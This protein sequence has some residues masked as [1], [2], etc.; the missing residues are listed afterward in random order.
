MF[1]HITNP[2]I[3]SPIYGNML[4][5]SPRCLSTS[6][7]QKFIERLPTQGPVEECN[8]LLKN[9]SGQLASFV[10]VPVPIGI[11]SHQAIPNNSWYCIETAQQQAGRSMEFIWSSLGWMDWC[12]LKR[13]SKKPWDSLV[14]PSA[15][16]VPI[17]ISVASLIW[18][19]PAR[20][21]LKLKKWQQHTQQNC[22]LLSP[23]ESSFAE[24]DS[25]LI[26]INRSVIW[27]L[28]CPS[29]WKLIPSGYIRC[30]CPAQPWAT[31]VVPNWLVGWLV[32]AGVLSES[33]IGFVRLC[34]TNS[35]EVP[36]TGHCSCTPW[37]VL[38]PIPTLMETY[39][40]FTI[41]SW[42]AILCWI[43]G[44]VTLPV[45]WDWSRKRAR[46]TT[47]KSM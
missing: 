22:V 34:P 41:C 46:I 32:E 27:S 6:K 3:C 23:V 35:A 1:K 16:K 13:P 45:P 11:W 17:W 47:Q 37:L 42:Q 20:D 21:G 9:E 26:E 5:S 43:P 19:L 44:D 4:K 30:I 36:T 18:A 39:F 29:C 25:T 40:S 28:P 12:P 31:R 2:F 15:E 8:P 10:V 7:Y 33:Q 24:C 38:H 14:S